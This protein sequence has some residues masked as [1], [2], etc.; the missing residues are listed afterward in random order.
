MHIHFACRFIYYHQ[1][2][3][4]EITDNGIY[5]LNVDR[6]TVEVIMLQIK[7]PVI[8]RSFTVNNKAGIIF[9][10]SGTY[11][12]QIEKNQIHGTEGEIVVG[13]NDLL[14]FTNL[15]LLGKDEKPILIY[16]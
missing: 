13:E 8:L 11:K 7:G 10:L 9:W 15:C 6:K 3:K 12:G 16:Y 14:R 1:Q 5:R 4:F 2:N